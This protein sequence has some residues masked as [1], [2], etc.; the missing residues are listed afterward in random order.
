MTQRR[1][2]RESAL[3][4]LYRFD[5]GSEDI[6]KSCAEVLR[7]R[8]FTPSGKD[9]FERLIETAITNL[10]TI[11][12]II[13]QTLTHWS[14]A[15]LTGVDRAILR[16]ACCELIYLPDIPPKVVINEALEIAKRYSTAESASFVNGV[17]DAIY[18]HKRE[19]K[20]YYS[21]NTK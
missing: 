7:K 6:K 10:P 16:I 14:L 8:K 18:Q 3:E 20:D 5:L 19:N 13:K 11:D 15:R 2:A 21:E 1:S 4:V 9:F 12:K 17:L